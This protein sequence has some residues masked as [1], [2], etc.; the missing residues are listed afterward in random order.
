M[1][2]RLFLRAEVFIP[3]ESVALWSGRSGTG[4]AG[5]GCYSAKAIPVRA[6]V[7]FFAGEKDEAG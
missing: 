3:A 6:G 4:D 2:A 1:D 5:K 7:P